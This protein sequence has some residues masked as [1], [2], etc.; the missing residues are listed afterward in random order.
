MTIPCYVCSYV[1]PDTDGVCSAIG[2][3]RLKACTT[4]EAYMPAVFGAL[5]RE[6]AFVLEHFGTAA[7]VF[8]PRL[9]R[10]CRIALVD[11]HHVR[12]LPPGL[13]LTQVVEILDHHPA[14]DPGA[15]PR[16]ELHNE[17]VG[18]AATLVAERF[19][20]CG[21]EPDRAT[22]GLLVA[23]IVSNTLDFSAPST[24]D[25]DREACAWLKQFVHIEEGFVRRM[26]ACRAGHEGLPTGELLRADYKEFSL[27]GVAVGISQ[28]ETPLPGDITGR[29]DLPA[30]LLR[31]QADRHMDHVFLN[32]VD[33]VRRCSVIVCC[34]AATGE[35]L[36]KALGADFKSGRAR[37]DRMLLRKTD[38]VPRLQALLS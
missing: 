33:M 4:G 28:I 17:P 2:Y 14:G 20:A 15:F 11:T 22:A 26:L 25:R 6:T 34:A 12:Q 21:R 23:A 8:D 32:C 13:P 3:A 38:L 5:T 24:S 16:A 30:C 27:G 37:F 18:A 31:L 9:P 7:P 29:P 10:R 35:L 1:N 36:T 19:T